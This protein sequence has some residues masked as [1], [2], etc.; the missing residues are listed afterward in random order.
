[1]RIISFSSHS[2]REFAM[3]I[4]KHS[5]FRLFADAMKMSA[6]ANQV[7]ALRLM[8]IAQGG[9]RAKRESRLM[10]QEKLDAAAKA[11]LTA[12]Q[13]IARGDATHAPHRA[14]AVYQKRVTRNLRR[15]SK[16]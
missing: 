16:G 1:M 12:A 11:G 3:R 8:K 4:R 7:I 5:M 2:F 9:P 6:D 14:L 15:L 10:V 13:A